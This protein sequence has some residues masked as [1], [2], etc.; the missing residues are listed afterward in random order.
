MASRRNFS[1]FAGAV[2]SRR[3][4]TRALRPNAHGAGGRLARAIG[5]ILDAIAMRLRGRLGQEPKVDELGK[6]GIAFARVADNHVDHFIIAGV[7]KWFLEGAEKERRGQQQRMEL[8]LDVGPMRRLQVGIDPPTGLFKPFKLCLQHRQDG[9]LQF[10]YDAVF[11]FLPPVSGLRHDPQLHLLQ[12][13]PEVRQQGLHVGHNQLEFGQDLVIFLPVAHKLVEF[14]AQLIPLAGQHRP[15]LDPA[16]LQGNL[17][18][19]DRPHVHQIGNDAPPGIN[20]LV[21]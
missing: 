12:P 17:A 2:R 7:A 9:L 16:V 14:G 21:V 4:R 1:T 6:Q 13:E 15:H 20:G 19:D 3:L 8:A 18:K 10:A 5:K 11:N